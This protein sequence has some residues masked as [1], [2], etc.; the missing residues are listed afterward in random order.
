[1]G[2][3]DTVFGEQIIKIGEKYFFMSLYPVLFLEKAVYSIDF[4]SLRGR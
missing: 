2:A 4:L 3:L 1:M